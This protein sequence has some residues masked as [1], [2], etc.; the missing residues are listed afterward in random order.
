[1]SLQSVKLA[2]ISSCLTYIDDVSVCTK[3]MNDYP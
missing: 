3:T 1:V 2:A